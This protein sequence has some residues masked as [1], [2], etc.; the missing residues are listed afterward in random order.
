MAKITRCE[1]A[2]KYDF[3]VVGSGNGACA[4]LRQYLACSSG[5]KILVLEEGDNF[6]ETSEITHQRNWTQ[7]YA[8]GNIF[9]LHT[10]QTSDEIPILSGRACTMGGGGS[11]NYTMIFESSDWLT[12]NLGHDQAYWDARK[13]EL[14]R[15]FERKDPTTNLTAVARH[16]KK[17]L[18]ELDFSVNKENN[19]EIGKHVNDHILLPFGIYLLPQTL[20]VTLKDQYVSL[21][22]T[23]EEFAD[24]NSQ[25]EPTI[26][27]FDFFSGE[28]GVLLYLI[29]HLFL[30]FWV[31][32]WLKFWMIR[33]PGVF[34]C[35]KRVS[36]TLV[37]ILNALDDILWS[38]VNPFKMGKHQ[39]NLI[40]AI[41]KFNI[42]REGYYEPQP[43]CLV[44]ENKKTKLY[45][46]VLRC[47]EDKSRKNDP[48]FRVAETAIAKQIPLMESLGEKP[49]PIFQFL[50]RLL[51]RMPYKVEQIPN[52][53]N[54]YSRYDLLT[55]QHLSGG[56]VF[57]KALDLGLR[58]PKDT[59]KVLGSQNIYVAD[60]SAS[61]LPRVSPQM[62]AYLIGHHVATQ[63][64]K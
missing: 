27:N 56:C 9:K 62:T 34:N 37:R 2:R 6:F 60:L 40:S 11:I 3:I 7:S 54:H 50:I 14:A 20:Q 23:T 19:M 35:L 44:N 1:D 18:E 53:I 57:G 59:G 33:K 12:K 46:I 43:V 28:L 22:A 21:F 26:C 58:S 63:I 38:I 24:D 30:A 39:W 61:P 5:G 36:R 47:F 42:A 17:K 48:D 49:H 13:E 15:S 31:P 10:A 4:F 45:Q 32:N 8:E 64:T 41:V 51:T 52:Y 25:G 16:V 55:E 29:S